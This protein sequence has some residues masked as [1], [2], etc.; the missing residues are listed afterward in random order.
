MRLC[1][2][3]LEG[4]VTQSLGAGEPPGAFEHWSRHVHP[5]G[6]SADG[7]A[8]GFAGGLAC[9]AADVEDVVVGAHIGSGAKVQVVAAQFCVVEVAVAGVVHGHGASGPSRS[10][11]RTPSRD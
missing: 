11:P 9:T 8:G 4:D 6:A 2:A 5:Q 7:A 10:T 1:V 3:E